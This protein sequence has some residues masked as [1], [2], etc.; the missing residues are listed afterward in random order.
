MN[1]PAVQLVE[2]REVAE[3]NLQPVVRPQ[4]AVFLNALRD[5][6]TVAAEFEWGSSDSR[7]RWALLL[8]GLIQADWEHLKVKNSIRGSFTRGL[9]QEMGAMEVGTR[10]NV[11]VAPAFDSSNPFAQG[12]GGVDELELY[13]LGPAQ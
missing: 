10:E 6:R 11:H 12:L 13:Q 8:T 9:Q 3:A 1:A 5:G 4:H 2:T 7:R